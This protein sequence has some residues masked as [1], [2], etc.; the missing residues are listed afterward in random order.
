MLHYVAR[1][2]VRYV[3]LAVASR[4]TAPQYT[5]QPGYIDQSPRWD[6]SRRW[7]HCL[8]RRMPQVVNTRAES[9]IHPPSPSGSSTRLQSCQA[10]VGSAGLEH[11]G[12]LIRDK[13]KSFPILWYPETLVN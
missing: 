12:V 8:V 2:T 11:G 5:R 13:V 6:S 4:Y 7:T 9:R 10:S 3:R 1:Y